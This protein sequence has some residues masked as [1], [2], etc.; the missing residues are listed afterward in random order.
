LYI[1]AVVQIDLTPYTERNLL[2]AHAVELKTDTVFLE[3]LTTGSKSLFKLVDTNGK[4][5]FIVREGK[6]FTTLIYKEYLQ[7][8]NG[9][10]KL[11]KVETYKE[12][13]GHYLKDCPDIKEQIQ[14]TSYHY[15]HLVNLFSNYYSCSSAKPAYVKKADKF[16]LDAGLLLGGSRTSLTFRSQAFKELANTQYNPFNSPVL[17]VFLDLGFPIN[18]KQ[19]SLANE[20]IYT[21]YSVK[22]EY[23]DRESKSIFTVHTTSFEYHY[24][25]LNTLLRYKYPLG[26]SFI[27]SNVGISNG[28]AVSG[29]NHKKQERHLYSSI[30]SSEGVALQY[31]QQHELGYICGIGGG[32]KRVHLELRYEGG[33]GMSKLTDPNSI[34][35]RLYGLLGYAF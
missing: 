32:Y 7:T 34:T 27:Y 14:S 1:S 15:R 8:V 19:W 21:G 17:G 33:S 25:K 31:T 9:G 29:S 11:I 10:N 35:R 5:H 30:T 13:L 26:K 28:L 24:L 20:L 22:G 23:T 16:R 12:Q 4:T 6:N 18:N 3:A 2:F